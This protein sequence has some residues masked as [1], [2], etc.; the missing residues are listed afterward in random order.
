MKKITCL[1]PLLFIP[2]LALAAPTVE[3]I[4]GGAVQDIGGVIQNIITWILGFAALL[5]VLFIIWGGILYIVSAGN[6]D[7]A[8]SARQTLTYAVIGLIVVILAYFIVRFVEA[9][10]KMLVA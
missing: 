9:F 5:A 8:K 4:D 10:A 2:T 6:S 7:R 3:I 1:I